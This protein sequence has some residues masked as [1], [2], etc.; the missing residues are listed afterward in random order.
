MNGNQKSFKL[1]K[2][3]SFMSI[4][5]MQLH[6]QYI[7][8]SQSTTEHSSGKSKKI[9]VLQIPAVASHLNSISLTILQT[10]SDEQHAQSFR[11]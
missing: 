1:P 6:L 10:E 5:Q 2:C 9:V 11:R 8:S 7:Q 4:L 3:S